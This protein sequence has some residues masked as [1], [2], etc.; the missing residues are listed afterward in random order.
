MLCSKFILFLVILH[1]VQASDAACNVEVDWKLQM[2]ASEQVIKVREGGTVTFTWG[3]HHNVAE[4]DSLQKY[5]ACD[6]T[7]AT[8][9]S[10]QA[11]DHD[12]DCLSL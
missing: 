9:L 6:L 11:A 12:H 3:G 4:V 7:G 2:S 8:V 10:A 5:K 1:G